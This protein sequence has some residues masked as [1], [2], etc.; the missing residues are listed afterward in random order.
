M[1]LKRGASNVTQTVHRLDHKA[2]RL[3]DH[4]RRRGA[5]VTLTT[6]PWSAEQQCTA[7]ARGSH[8]SSY[9]EREFVHQ[10][11]YDFCQQGYWLVLPFEVVKGWPSLRIS[12]LGVVPQRDRRPRLIVD[13]TWSQVNQDTLKLAPTEAMQFGRT[14]HRVLSNIVHADPRYGPVKLA[15][16]DI[17]DGFYRVWIQFYD[18]PKLGVVL[19]TAPQMPAL[20]AFPLALPM[21]WVESPPYFTCLTETACDLAN[22]RLRGGHVS[23]R[24]HRLEGLAA[25]SPPTAAV[26][27]PARGW[28][29]RQ[30]AFGYSRRPPLASVDVYVDDFI[31]LS[32]TQPTATKVLRATFEAIDTV[33]RPLSPHD[34]DVR[35]EPA[36]VKKLRQGDAS[37][38]TNKVL[39][40]WEVDTIAGTIT[41]P[42]RRLDRLH[43]LLDVVRPPRKRLST[44]RWHQL[45][46]ELRSMALALPGSLGL[47]SAMQDALRYADRH[48]IRLNR[49]IFAAIDDFRAIAATLDSRPTR[50]MELVPLAPSDL[51][52]CDACRQGMGG[53]WLDALD[54]TTP[55]ILWRWPFP[56]FLQADLV[57]ADNRA[58][59]VS[60]SDFELAGI[61]AHKDVLARERHVH[62][63]TIWIA[64]DN[65]AALSWAT[66]GSVTASSARAYLLRLNALHQRQHRYVARHHYI[67]GA[68]NAM[69]DDASRLWHLSN[70]ELISHF[71]LTYP[72]HTSWEMRTLNPA[73]AS[74]LIGALSR[75]PLP[76]AAVHNAYTPRQ[77]LGSS[78]RPFV[79][80]WASAPTPW[81]PATPYLFSNSSPSATALANSPPATSLSALG[82]WRT[83]YAMWARRTPHW[84]PQTLV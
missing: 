40:G 84:G 11:I 20:V 10:E 14:L 17:A 73:F 35:K 9:G 75:R 15:K 83:P 25:T 63:R 31:L 71:N 72:Q 53:V 54:P 3:L 74:S 39:L 58:G 48:R 18:V 24:A 69:A 32:Q 21:G 67:P 43:T 36:S 68:V 60:I 51:G 37:W 16:I 38:S 13:Y 52:A 82:Q 50:L 46:G 22:A 81:G 62:E 49:H 8:Q 76:T 26:S 34:P 5:G 27:A 64:G 78:G 7:I 80:A 77:P 23:P 47:F 55:P 61:L 33:F 57:T 12:P 66:K 29:S 42:P 79:P 28:A 56:S 1:E 70:A 45:L 6:A 19:P 30:A 41:L 59:S 2:A 4:L 44:K 65:R